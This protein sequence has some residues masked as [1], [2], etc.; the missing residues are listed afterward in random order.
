ML[1]T[2]AVAPAVAHFY[3]HRGALPSFVRGAMRVLGVGGSLALVVIPFIPRVG[4]AAAGLAL[5]CALLPLAVRWPRDVVV[6]ALLLPVVAAWT[7]GLERSLHWNANKRAS[8]PVGQLLRR[9]LDRRDAAGALATYGH[10]DAPVLLAA[11]LLPP[12]SESR[13]QLPEQRWLLRE[14]LF[15]QPF[16]SDE[17]VERLRLSTARKTYVLH[18]RPPQ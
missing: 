5:A 18:E 10:V 12:G 9:E 11:G 3:A 15:W 13:K 8:G 1:F 17:H 2:F 6:A 4:V 7:V 16:A 14:D